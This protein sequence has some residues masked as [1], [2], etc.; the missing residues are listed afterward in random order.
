MKP[1]LP[2]LELNKEVFVTFN[3]GSMAEQKFGQSI[4][5]KIIELKN[6]FLS[7]GSALYQ[8][9]ISRNLHNQKSDLLVLQDQFGNTWELPVDDILSLSYLG[10]EN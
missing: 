7:E 5:G 3:K 8:F 9:Y 1:G 6:D 4:T 2:A 10:P